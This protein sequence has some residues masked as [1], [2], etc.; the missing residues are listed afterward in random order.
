M[1]TIAGN[2]V[3][4]L[5]YWK[6]ALKNRAFRCCFQ[7]E[8]YGESP[9]AGL[10]A[11]SLERPR[12]SAAGASRYRSAEICERMI[13]VVPRPT[14][15]LYKGRGFMFF[16]KN[17]WKNCV[18]ADTLR[19][20]CYCSSAFSFA[21]PKENAGASEMT[22]AERAAASDVSY[23]LCSFLPFQT[24]NCIRG[25]AGISISLRTSLN[26]PRKPLRFSWIFPAIA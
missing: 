20:I 9:S 21:S 15:P 2:V 25:L 4:Y 3:K 12:E 16:A 5:R 22:T 14:S 26:R 7:R 18:K 1:L 8:G 13:R 19:Q 23:P 10:S 6:T 17:I 24:A 11:A